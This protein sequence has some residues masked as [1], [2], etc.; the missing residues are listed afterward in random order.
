MQTI[1]DRHPGRAN[2]TCGRED[3][4]TEVDG[5]PVGTDRDLQKQILGQESRRDGATER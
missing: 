1:M 2:P 3:V 5:V 4:I